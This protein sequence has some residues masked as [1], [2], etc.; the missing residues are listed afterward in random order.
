VPVISPLGRDEAG[1]ILNINADIAAGAVA[2]ALGAAKMIYLSDVLGIMRDPKEPDSLIPTLPVKG[3]HQLIGEGIIAGGMLP[4]VE[5]A[6]SAI[7]NGVGKVH[8]IDGR[9]PHSLLLEIF[10]NS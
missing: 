3:V 10:T 8:F 2:A 9:I 6:I 7:Q 1:T 4:K 5:S